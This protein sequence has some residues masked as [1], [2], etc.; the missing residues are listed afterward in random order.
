MSSRSPRGSGVRKTQNKAPLACL[1]CRKK[2]V[3]C[4]G[5]VPCEYCQKR[6][7]QCSAPLRQERKVYSVTHV[8]D[9]EN[10]LAQYEGRNQDMG[11]WLPDA[12]DDP[13][14]SPLTTCHN[15]QQSQDTGVPAPLPI[16][17][18]TTGPETSIPL[19]GRSIETDSSLSSSATFGFRI[20]NLLSHARH[21]HETPHLHQL[22]TSVTI[23]NL[24][25]RRPISHIITLCPFYPANKKP[26]VSLS[27]LAYILARVKATSTSE[28]F[29]IISSST[30]LTRKVSWDH[31]RHGFCG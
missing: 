21:I 1:T 31:L 10:R 6:G 19:T 27:S 24:L 3:K 4:S 22:P 11:E 15:A 25:Q 2:K 13:S 12:A 26:T 17:R 9:L 30:M 18:P 23:T 8:E 28:K 29:Q 16:S 5:I 7:L 20:Q 14:Q